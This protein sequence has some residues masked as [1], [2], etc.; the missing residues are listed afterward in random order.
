MNGTEVPGTAGAR[1]FAGETWQYRE[2]T[3]VP[4]GTQ[5][6][7]HEAMYVCHHAG[8]VYHISLIAL[9][10]EFASASGTEFPIVITNFQ[11]TS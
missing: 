3:W 1:T 10:A 6:P 2:S 5:P 4:G 7:L 8:L 11:F 9:D